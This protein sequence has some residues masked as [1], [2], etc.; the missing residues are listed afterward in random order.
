MTLPAAGWYPDPDN[1]HQTRWWNGVE[2]TE[3]R[4]NFQAPMPPVNPA[5]YSM[6]TAALTAPAGTK[7]N[8]PWVWL[9]VVV[10]YIPVLGI[11]FI[12]WP[13]MFTASSMSSGMATLSILTSPAYLFTVLGGF[14]VYGLAVWF[15]YL[16]YRELE[17]RS[18]PRPFHWAWTFLSSGVYPIGRS[19]IVRR[20]IGHGISPMWVTIALMASSFILSIAFSVWILSLVFAQIPTVTG[21]AA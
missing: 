20:R 9:V 16:D 7:W 14:V 18:V 21:Y 1:A 17:R 11:F 15:A 12:D 6:S 8:T 4:S 2:W 10:P 19:V 13:A 3:D 5:S